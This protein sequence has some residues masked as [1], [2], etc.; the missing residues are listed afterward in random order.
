MPGSIDSVSIMKRHLV[1]V[2]K[3]GFVRAH[4]APRLP[5]AA[6]GRIR[7][8]VAR[9]GPGAEVP[10]GP[11]QRPPGGL[12]DLRRGR[13]FTSVLRL[14]DTPHPRPDSDRGPESPSSTHTQ[15]MKVAV[16]L[17]PAPGAGVSS[18]DGPAPGLRRASTQ[19]ASDQEVPQYGPI[20]DRVAAR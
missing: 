11:R 5:A 16:S 4:N 6:A 7:E 14:R 18:T 17:P 9:G 13:R 12:C 20:Q 15:M 3:L 8:R 10:A 1:S 19:E 2:D